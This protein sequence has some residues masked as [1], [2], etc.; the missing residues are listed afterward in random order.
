M[1][2]RD[3]RS[4]YLLLSLILYALLY[5]FIII[6]YFLRL[7]SVLT[8][9]FLLVLFFISYFLLGFQKNKMNSIRKETST[10]I[11][12]CVLLY[13]ILIYGIG[14]F[15]GFLKNSYSMNIITMIGNVFSP[16][17]IIIFEELFRYNLIR[18]NKD[19]KYIVVLTAACLIIFDLCINLFIKDYT[20]DVIFVQITTIGLPIFV[21]HC[22]MTYLSLELGYIPILFYRIMVEI[23]IFIVPVI[24]DIGNYF[25]SMLGIIM[26]LIIFVYCSR[27]IK[28]Y[29][30]GVERDFGKKMFSIADI[31]I[32]L[33][34]VVLM[35]LVSGIFRYQLIGVASG[36][37][38]PIIKK[39]D[40]VMID[41]KILVNDL[42]TGDIIAYKKDNLII[43]HR[44][45]NVNIEDDIVIFSTKGDA[46]NTEDDIKL[47]I[48]DIK[49]KVIFDVPYIAWPSVYLSELFN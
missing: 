39:G 17:F 40:A 8:A 38:N 27:M 15:T 29:Y 32:A 21:K 41:Q 12:I 10:M 14:F 4:I 43:I 20:F 42:K 18:A 34:I 45:V 1:K 44:I 30:N 33:I 22:V 19:K 46:N 23:Y 11:V 5:R 6:K 48:D 3:F 25:I 16:L 31:P 35:I 9:T 24:P 36:S 28:E 2:K 26:P 49:G 7:S 47:S 13:F 37:M